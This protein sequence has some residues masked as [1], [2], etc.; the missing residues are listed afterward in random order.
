MDQKNI[1]RQPARADEQAH[2]GL[3]GLIAHMVLIREPA[4]RWRLWLTALGG[5]A[6]LLVAL[7]IFPSFAAL[8]F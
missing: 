6:L 4:D 5:I 3:I 8:E 1:E 2:D 7:F